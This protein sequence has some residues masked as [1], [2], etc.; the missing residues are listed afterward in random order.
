MLTKQ[1]GIASVE[2]HSFTK[3]NFKTFR[4]HSSFR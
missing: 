2:F 3:D 4:F 1:K